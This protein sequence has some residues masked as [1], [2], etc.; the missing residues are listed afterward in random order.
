[1][2][3]VAAHQRH[4][5]L[6]DLREY[7]V[8][9]RVPI[10]VLAV[11]EV[12]AVGAG[13]SATAQPAAQPV[14]AVDADGTKR[15]QVHLFEEHEAHGTTPTVAARRVDRTY[16]SRNK[17]RTLGFLDGRGNRLDLHA[18]RTA[19]LDHDLQ[20]G[21]RRRGRRQPSQLQ[22]A[23]DAGRR[24]RHPAILTLSPEERQPVE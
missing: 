14:A 18:G 4:Q 2:G 9:A 20:R 10:A 5:V 22:Q 1:M 8:E 17:L 15:G 7:D 16:D 19:G 12:A 6:A 3:A 13:G 11:A 23:P 24:V 21:G